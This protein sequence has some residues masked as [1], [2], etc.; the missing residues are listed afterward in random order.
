[1]GKLKVTPIR[2]KRLVVLEHYG[3]LNKLLNKMLLHAHRN[4]DLVYNRS[5]DRGVVKLLTKR[6]NPKVSYSSLDIEVLN[7]LNNLG[8]LSPN[9][10]NRKTKLSHP[11]CGAKQ[12][13]NPQE[14][15]DRLRVVTESLVAGNR[16]H[17]LA[18]EAWEIIVK[19]LHLN[20]ITKGQHYTY[21]NIIHGSNLDRVLILNSVDRDSTSRLQNFTI[22]FIPPIEDLGATKEQLYVCVDK[23]NMSYS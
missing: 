1:M 6:Y 17:Q 18:N 12:F 11:G 23:T 19:S 20:F 9:P 22:G 16:N 4:G 7:D 21:I 8:G 13:T 3:D 14:L 2:F 15:M 5:V 10:N